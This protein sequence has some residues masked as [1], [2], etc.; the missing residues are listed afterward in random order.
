MRYEQ[1][2]MRELTV[3]T[4]QRDGAVVVFLRGDAGMNEA[5]HLNLELTRLLTQR[6]RLTVIDLSGLTLMASITIG[7]LVAYKGGTK[8]QGGVTKLAGARGNVLESLRRSRIDMVIPLF[9]T[10]DQAIG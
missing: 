3:E 6:P 4:E 1:T 8:V 7:A 5:E 9:E 10:V 2:V